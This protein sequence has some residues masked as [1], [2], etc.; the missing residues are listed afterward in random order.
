VDYLVLFVADAAGDRHADAFRAISRAV[1]GTGF[2]DDPSGGE[3]RT[4]GAYAR[5]EALDEPAAR[6][7]VDEV[8]AV[9][10][11]SGARIEVQFREDILGHI[12]NGRPDEQL[13]AAL[14]P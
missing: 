9:S 5:V 11:R 10:A 14:T 4:V 13:R 3:Q 7:L 6:T 2:F 1:P 12:D 8:A